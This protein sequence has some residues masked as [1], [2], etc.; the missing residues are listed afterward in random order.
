MGAEAG[1]VGARMRGQRRDAGIC[2]WIPDL[3]CAVPRRRQKRVFGNE[4]PVD[5]KD[6]A[7]VLLPRG[8]G[9]RG[10][11]DVEELDGAVA[12]GRQQLV[13]VR[14]RPRAVE[15]G[16]LRVEPGPAGSG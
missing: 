12:A 3:D 15:E 11:V 6:F 4:V 5:G 7:R 1:R 13:L 10:H 2:I 8:N 9:V 16:V 14:F